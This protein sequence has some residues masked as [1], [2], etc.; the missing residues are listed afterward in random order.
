MESVSCPR[1]NLRSAHAANARA[2]RGC[3]QLQ[4][5]FG[6]SSFIQRGGSFD[7]FARRRVCTIHSRSSPSS[8]Q[9]A[10]ITGGEQLRLSAFHVT[11]LRDGAAC[12]A[13]Q[14]ADERLVA[15]M[16]AKPDSVAAPCRSRPKHPWCACP[17]QAR[18]L[19]TVMRFIVPWVKRNGRWYS[20]SASGT[21]HS[22]KKVRSHARCASASESSSAM[23][24]RAAAIARGKAS[25]GVIAVNSA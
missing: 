23:A 15:R 5:L 12:V 17:A 10:Q 18:K 24:F 2:W 25:D 8:T 11:Q 21:F 13:V 19:H 6:R 7:R 9:S 4:P 20:F 3:H 22:N 14:I 1:S 16:S